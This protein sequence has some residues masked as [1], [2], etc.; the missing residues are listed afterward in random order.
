MGRRN[1]WRPSTMVVNFQRFR[2]NGNVPYLAV[3]LLV[4]YSRD[5][6]T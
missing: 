5:C 4:S 2:K 6:V 3:G 1:K